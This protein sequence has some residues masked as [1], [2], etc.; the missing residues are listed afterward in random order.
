MTVSWN[1]LL[2][3]TP[4]L[5]CIHL[6]LKKIITSTIVLTY[7][8]DLREIT[9]TSQIYNSVDYYN[10]YRS[11]SVNFTR[12][13]C[14]WSRLKKSIAKNPWPTF[15][16]FGHSLYLCLMYINFHFKC[17]WQFS[18]YFSSEKVINLR[19]L[20]QWEIRESA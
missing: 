16:F 4:D 11:Y 20:P 19:N 18:S 6:N 3:R 1:I 17:Q 10:S 7:L 14:T 8:Y 12:V 15:I 13:T 2:I 5:K 9:L